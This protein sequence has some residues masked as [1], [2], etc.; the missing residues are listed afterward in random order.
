[1]QVLR[2]Q[3]ALRPSTAKTIHRCQ[4]DTIKK[5][6]LVD[7]QG[8]TQPHIHYVAM[9]RADDLQHLH[10]RNFDPK[11]ITVSRDVAVEMNRLRV[12][13][14]QPSSEDPAHCFK[15]CYLNAQSLHRH[16]NDVN[17]DPR[18]AAAGLLFC[19]ETRFQKED[20]QNEVNLMNFSHSIR[21]DEPKTTGIRP[22]HGMACFS[23][24]HV[25]VDVH[26]EGGIEMMV[27]SITFSH[28]ELVHVMAVYIPPRTSIQHTT[29]VLASAISSHKLV[30]TSSIIM[31]D[32]N[33]DVHVNSSDAARLQNFFSELGFKQ[34]ITNAQQMVEQ[35][36]TMSTQ[37]WTLLKLVYWRHII[38]ITRLY[39][40][41]Y[42]SSINNV[43][44]V[45]WI[46]VL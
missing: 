33:T 7:F 15:I 31:G 29:A 3:F 5:Y 6:M 38:P 40:V 16:L 34:R 19:S 37:G 35:L 18:L 41:P 43:L 9:S 45:D 2:T 44:S 24:T 10:L 20:Q 30:P 13:N 42:Y 25:P 27:A 17:Q 26:R 32:F 28:G 12:D 1:M 22:F 4:G 11:K 23:K 21:H 8:R 36:L 39:G 46:I 14:T